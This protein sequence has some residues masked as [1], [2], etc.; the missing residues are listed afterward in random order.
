V[1]PAGRH[2]RHQPEGSAAAVDELDQFFALSLD[3]LCIFNLDG[4]FHR[5]NPAWEKTLGFSA[6]E[7]C[8]KPWS[9]FIHP[10]DRP[11]AEAALGELRAG[12]QIDQLEVRFLSK[13]GA[14]RWLV[15]S[16][17]PALEQGAVFAAVSDITDR[18]NLEEQLKSQNAALEQQ[19]RLAN[20]ASRLKSEFLANMSHE[21]RSPLNG[22]IGFTE[23]LYDGKLGPIPERPRGFLGRIHASASHLLQLING[24]LDLSKVE[25]GR[26]EFRPERVSV[27]RLIREVTEILGTQATEKQIRVE[28]EIDDQVDQVT[29][30]TGRLKQILYNY[31][32]NA[33]KFTGPGGWVVVRLKADG[34]REFRI[35]VSDSGI[36]IAEKDLARLFVEF[37][38][39]DATAAKRHQ[40][41]GLG[42]ALT[43]RIVEAQGGR[44]GVESRPGQGST[45]FAVLPRSP[46]T[47]PGW[48]GATVLVIENP[49]VERFLTA[50]VLQGAGYRVETA[51]SCQEALEKCRQR[52]FDAVALD[53]LLPDGTGWEALGRIRS[54]KPWNTPVVV[55]STLEA[56][57]LK[58]IPSE[59]RGFLTTS[60]GAEDLLDALERTILEMKPV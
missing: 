59:V 53:V 25:A 16:A 31:L 38:Q 37:Q 8:S 58:R 11:R 4:Y 36:G 56:K 12:I 13:S 19:N 18:K 5:L 6:A 55:V 44:V 42:L 14:Y 57:E 51:T 52:R 22:V 46:L 29:T 3:L 43:K 40:G 39:L 45:F 24:V 15:G 34:A 47:D 1:L 27:S 48:C 28:T 60:R 30:D 26:L 20:E 49:A 21:L 54:M 23:L 9:E 50:R 7:L 33:L 41:T 2:Q 35:E 10:E 17:T 32:S